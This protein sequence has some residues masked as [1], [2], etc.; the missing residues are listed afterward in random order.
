[1]KPSSFMMPTKAIAVCL[2]AMLAM[3]SA[4]ASPVIHSHMAEEDARIVERHL[5]IARQ[6]KQCLPNGMKEGE[7][8]WDCNKLTGDPDG[9]A[10]SLIKPDP[11]D[12]T[13][14]S[15]YVQERITMKYGQEKPYNVE[16]D[17]DLP[18]KLMVGKS[19]AKT[20]SV[21]I[22]MKFEGGLDSDG[23]GPKAAFSLGASWSWSETITNTVN[24]ER[25]WAPN[26]TDKYFTECGYFT[27]VPYMIESCG[28]LSVAKTK[29]VG[30]ENAGYEVACMPSQECDKSQVQTTKNW[31]NT[32]PVPAPEDTGSAG[33][34]GRIIF[35]KKI[36]GE[37]TPMPNGQNIVYYSP[38]VSMH[39]GWTG[40]IN[41][42]D[43]GN[44]LVM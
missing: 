34:W 11:N 43:R 41:T 3:E 26:A 36:C 12:P 22:N 25:A 14:C 13:H 38:G 27:F 1:M 29:P 31:C 17:I 28:T 21:E 30:C 2:L 19:T 8:R 4:S 15:A 40:D 44:G 18:C 32:N 9:T 33:V 10:T 20:E 24:A 7:Q 16:C 5:N 6:G 35:V 39:Q 42:A 23:S 37:N